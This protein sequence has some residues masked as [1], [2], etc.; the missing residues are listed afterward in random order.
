MKPSLSHRI[1][2]AI[3]K[4]FFYLLYHQFA[5]LYDAV[6]WLVSF[7]RW[8]DWILAPLPHLRDDPI[9]EIGHGPGH[10]QQALYENHMKAYGLDESRQMCRMAYKRLSRC[11]YQPC[12]VNGYAQNLPFPPVSFSHVVA[13]FPSEYIFSQKTLS[14]IYRVLSPE[15]SL[16]VLPT[17]LI[18]GK[19]WI[20][21]FLR[22]LNHISRQAPPSLNDLFLEELSRPF[23][24]AG[25]ETTL[26]T[27]VIHDSQIVLI[28]ARKPS[29]SS[30]E[31]PPPT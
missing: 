15:G 8:Q 17:A 30:T 10:L 4:V 24:Q 16:V 19:G 9:L 22:W 31:S 23:R 3:L 29:L 11:G 21:R 27:P 7:G 18:L 6:A 1:L 12:I 2:S 13:T 20:D 28:L 5:W 26:L 25:F 14:E